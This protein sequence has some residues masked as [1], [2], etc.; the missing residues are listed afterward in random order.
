MKFLK[1]NHKFRKLIISALTLNFR[2]ILIS[3]KSTDNSNIKF[4]YAIWQFKT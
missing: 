1:H 2:N 3:I 4:V